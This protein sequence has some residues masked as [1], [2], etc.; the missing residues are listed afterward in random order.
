MSFLS[1]IQPNWLNSSKRWGERFFL[2]YTVAWVSLFGGVVVTEV[3]K[4]WGDV[5]YMSLGLLLALPLVLIPL[6]FPGASDRSL[7]LGSRYW[8][9]VSF[10]PPVRESQY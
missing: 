8:V 5:E 4:E 2:V 6:A 9:K 7:P 1:T 3:Y 10:S